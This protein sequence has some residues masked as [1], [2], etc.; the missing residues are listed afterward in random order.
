M[1]A[2]LRALLD[3]IVDYAGQFPPA[4][5]PLEAAIRNYAHYTATVESWMLAKFIHVASNLPDLEPYCEALFTP[6]A[7]LKVS[8]L[9]RGGS[10]PEEFL[11]GLAEDLKA[12]RSF[13]INQKGPGRVGAFE[14]RLPQS[15][16]QTKQKNA[17]EN[18]LREI[19]EQVRQQELTGLGLF[20]E[21]APA[22][23]F[24]EQIPEVV[25]AFR[26]YNEAGRRQ[27]GDQFAVVGFKL[28]CGGAEPSAYPNSEQVAVC[29]HQCLA[30]RIPF[31]ATAG[32]HHPVRHYNQ[33]AKTY[34]HGF[35]NVFGGGALGVACDAGEND[36]QNILED[37]DHHHFRVDNEGLHWNDFHA[38]VSEITK[39]REHALISFG[40]CSFDEP[41]EDLRELGWL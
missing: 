3:N 23:N 30:N 9:G 36:L 34:M 25:A 10:T 24:R 1:N 6:D 16:I 2:G 14:T 17:L 8:A 28:R 15:V 31:K 29:L 21:V 5:L 22:A 26:E 40:S 12:I 27:L 20:L 19:G 38:P 18:L 41:V 37:E 7:P 39:V 4:K 11:V 32:L 35:L 13:Q 33:G